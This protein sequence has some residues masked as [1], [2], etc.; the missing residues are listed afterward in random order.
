VTRTTSGFTLVEV[1]VATG[2]LL[3]TALGTAQLFGLAL[4]QNIFARDQ[5]LMTLLAA[6]A[7]DQIAAVATAGAIAASPPD[8]LD[9][10][11]DGF[12]DMAGEGEAVYARRWI[13]SFPPE[14]GGATAAIVVR[15]FRPGSPGS[16]VEIATVA[17]VAR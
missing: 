4:R 3:V 8:C 6:R 12:A 1:S 5:T 13:V 14:Q 7:L 11:C 17:E 2:I 16:R 9:R 10:D 15:V